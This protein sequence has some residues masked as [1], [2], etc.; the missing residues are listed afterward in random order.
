MSEPL[1]GVLVV[2][3]YSVPLVSVRPGDNVTGPDYVFLTIDE[4]MAWAVRKTDFEHVAE[5]VAN[6]MALGLGLPCHPKAGQ[7]DESFQ[8]QLENLH[9]ALRPVKTT[10]LTTI[11]TPTPLHRVK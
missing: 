6:A 11:P 8:R 1:L 2:D 4:R 9:A 10:E 3:G 5:L 7:V